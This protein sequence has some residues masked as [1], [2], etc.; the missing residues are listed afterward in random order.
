MA[1]AVVFGEASRDEWGE[2]VIHLGICETLNVYTTNWAGLYDC[3]C[4]LIIV[5][6]RTN[7]RLWTSPATLAKI[8]VNFTETHWT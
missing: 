3:Y 8:A 2:K 6:C 4:D 7:V 5:S 1:G